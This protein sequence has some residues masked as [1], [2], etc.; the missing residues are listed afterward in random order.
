VNNEQLNTR[1][2]HAL[3]QTQ[4][5]T[6]EINEMLCQTFLIVTITALFGAASAQ[7]PS[8]DTPVQCRNNAG[9]PV[10]WWVAYKMPK[11]HDISRGFNYTYADSDEPELRL[12]QAQLDDDGNALAKTLQQ[13]YL[14]PDIA[15]RH[16]FGFGMYND[17]TPASKTSSTF[18]HTKGVF[19]F[20]EKTAF[21]L[22]HS[23]PRFPQKA[24]YDRKRYDFPLDETTYG[25]SFLCIS[26]PPQELE[27]LAP[28]LQLNRPQLYDAHM[29][30]EF[31][32]TFPQLNATLNGAFHNKEG[33][34]NH[35][36]F[37]STGGKQF[38]SLA[39]NAKWGKDLYNDAVAP[40]VQGDLL[41]ETW[42]RP[43]EPSFCSTSPDEAYNVVNVAHLNVG[44]TG[45]GA[46]VFAFKETKDH[47]KW[48]VT[49][50]PQS[51]WL[52]IGDINH[53]YSQY[54]RAGG[55]VCFQDAPLHKSYLKIIAD[56]DEC[57]A[58]KM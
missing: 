41:V 21:W 15:H 48:A 40:F 9:Q 2:S 49:S 47:A 29:P 5:K 53:Q 30:V 17:E 19:A 44:S 51:N 22:V 58:K 31:Y 54:K 10:D 25:Q 1:H 37:K 23:V 32:D 7:P 56:V 33:L 27:N 14:R 57:P 35:V 39:K 13:I 28:N 43:V 4:H 8:D 46:S 18:G 42:M 11:I 50:A 45:D 24:S 16:K 55:T 38:T 26:M 20:N 36:A 12:A 3:S 6:N 52:C 34:L